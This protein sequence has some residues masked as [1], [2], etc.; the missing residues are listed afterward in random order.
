[1]QKMQKQMPIDGHCFIGGEAWK[2]EAKTR[3]IKWVHRRNC[4]MFIVP[5][6]EREFSCVFEWFKV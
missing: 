2:R 6:F 1:M 5:S 4:K 3:E